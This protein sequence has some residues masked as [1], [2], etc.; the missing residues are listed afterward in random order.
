MVREAVE[1]LTGVE[2]QNLN[3]GDGQGWQKVGQATDTGGA[4]PRA[5]RDAA[6]DPRGNGTRIEDFSSD[7]EFGLAQQAS[8]TR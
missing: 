6:A 2:S 8:A 7:Q 4:Q 3:F 5:E 1:E